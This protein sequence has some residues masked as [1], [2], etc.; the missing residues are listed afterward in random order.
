MTAFTIDKGYLSRILL[1]L[2]KKKLLETSQSAGDGR[3]I[4]LLLTLKGKQEFEKLNN[5][6]NKEVGS[7]LSKLTQSRCDEL[8][9]HMNEIKKILS[10]Q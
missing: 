5:A 6:A 10:A 4:I 3:S 2:Q 8:V 7:L 9:R 1:K